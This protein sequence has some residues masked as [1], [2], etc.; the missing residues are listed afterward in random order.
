MRCKHFSGRSPHVSAGSLTLTPSWYVPL[1][2]TVGLLPHVGGLMRQE[3][4]AE[5]R[6]GVILAAAKE[7]IAAGNAFAWTDCENGNRPRCPL[8]TRTSDKSASRPASAQPAPHLVAARPQPGAP[9]TAAH[10]QVTLSQSRACLSLQRSFSRLVRRVI[11][12]NQMLAQPLA[13]AC[14]V[15]PQRYFQADYSVFQRFF[16]RPQLSPESWVIDLPIVNEKLVYRN[17]HRKVTWDPMY[18]AAPTKT[19]PQ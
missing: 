1:T 12:P 17:P 16:L 9:I 7:D 19:V 14:W 2:R 10:I 4:L 6:A 15:C 8:W 18:Q 11:R 5:F 13:A 3:L